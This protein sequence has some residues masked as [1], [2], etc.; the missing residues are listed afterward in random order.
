MP[1]GLMVKGN[2]APSGSMAQSAGGLHGAG[3]SVTSD[4]CFACELQD[5]CRSVSATG[6]FLF[7]GLWLRCAELSRCKSRFC[8]SLECDGSP[9]SAPPPRQGRAPQAIC[10]ITVLPQC[11]LLCWLF[12]QAWVLCS[13]C[14]GV[15]PCAF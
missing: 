4:S 12:P 13:L 2:S 15:S 10:C 6:W 8:F 5:S 9:G 11:S 7:D 3:G 14:S 1:Q